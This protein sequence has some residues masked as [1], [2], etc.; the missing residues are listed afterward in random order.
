MTGHGLPMRGEE[1]S[2]GLQYLVDHFDQEMPQ[3]GRYVREPA[4]FDERGPSY[5]PPPVPD[6]FPK[7]VATVAVAAG[8]AAIVAAA[9]RRREE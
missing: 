9:V 1:L 4:V 2:R 8:L 6:P 7:A 5:V 3:D